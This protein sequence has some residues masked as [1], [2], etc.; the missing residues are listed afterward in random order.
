VGVQNPILL[1]FRIKQ[2]S[3][4]LSSILK[5]SSALRATTSFLIKCSSKTFFLSLLKFK[6]LLLRETRM[7]T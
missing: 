3:N 2:S 5:I 4:C 7:P 6:A 1:V